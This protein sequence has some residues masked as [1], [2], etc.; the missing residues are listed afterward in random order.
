MIEECM[1]FEKQLQD[2]ASALP[3]ASAEQWAVELE[4]E[5]WMDLDRLLNG[6][7]PTGEMREWL[8]RLKFDPGPG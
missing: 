1:E 6:G 3:E 4:F 7:D 8:E 5:K 2:A